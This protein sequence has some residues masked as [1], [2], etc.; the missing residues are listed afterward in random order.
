MKTKATNI[1][2]DAFLNAIVDEYK[3]QDAIT[4]VNLMK[5]ATRSE[6][7]MWGTSIVGFGDSSYK[8]SNGKEINWFKIGFSPRKANFALYLSTIMHMSSE[9]LKN[10]GKYKTAKACLYINKIEDINISVLDKLI[11]A[12]LS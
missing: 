9:L 12:S 11:K 10:L 8:L 2:V 5:K 1:S 3:R 7:R 6:P 4:I